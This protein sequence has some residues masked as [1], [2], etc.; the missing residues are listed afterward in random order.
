[1]FDGETEVRVATPGKSGRG[2]RRPGAGRKPNYLKKFSSRPIS[3]AE[4]ALDD[5]PKVRG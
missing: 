2:G 4:I 1:M 3:A 5:I